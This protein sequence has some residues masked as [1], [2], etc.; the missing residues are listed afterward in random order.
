M[1]SVTYNIECS[2]VRSEQLNTAVAVAPRWITEIRLPVNLSSKV[3]C[4]VLT[5]GI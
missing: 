4:I 1:Y 3:R 5:V 2:N